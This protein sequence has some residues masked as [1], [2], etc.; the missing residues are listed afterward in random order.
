MNN[1]I[2]HLLVSL[3]ALISMPAF[4]AMEIHGDTGVAVVSL[5]DLDLSTAAGR[6]TAHARV[7]Q[8]AKRLCGKLSVESDRSRRDNYFA[9][10]DEAVQNAMQK[11][12]LAGSGHKSST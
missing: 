2:R 8:T 11:L 5:G 9:C 12:E 3:L 6:S 4:A 7:E 10:V 1:S